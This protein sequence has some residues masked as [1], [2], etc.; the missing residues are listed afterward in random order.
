[1]AAIA[2][3]LGV[4]FFLG[5][6]DFLGGLQSKSR[7]VFA[8]LAVSQLTGLLALIPVIVF[9]HPAPSAWPYLGWAVLAG[10]SSVLGAS[11]LYRGLATGKMSVVAP[12]SATAA[13]VPI[14]VGVLAGERPSIAQDLGIAI[15]MVGVV[16]TARQEESEPGNWGVAPGA[17]F[18]FLAA[19]GGGCFLAAM[20]AASK[21]GIL[22]A[23]LTARLTMLTILVFVGVT[24]SAV[25]ITTRPNRQLA[26][27]GILEVSSWV[28]FAAATTLGLL[29][30]VGLLASLYPAVTVLLARNLLQEQ[31]STM[32]LTGLAL[33]VTGLAFITAG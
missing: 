30:I 23:A 17:G 10:A 31:V 7:P 3:A 28:M 33:V 1:M 2:L 4:S 27:I 9:F 14:A 8:V 13:I 16:A 29:A 24:F 19:L 12:I 32:Q 26:A 5:T 22:W 15:A 6:S 21:G 20:G 18:A 11:S 25:V